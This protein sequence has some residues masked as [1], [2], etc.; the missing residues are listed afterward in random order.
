MKLSFL[1]KIGVQK[2]D[3]QERINEFR[4]F[5]GIYSKSEEEIK[6]LFKTF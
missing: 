5:D 6:E 4:K 1:Q 3:E 2:I